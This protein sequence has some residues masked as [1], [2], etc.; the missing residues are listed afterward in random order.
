MST[1]DKAE[2]VI[3]ETGHT[4]VITMSPDKVTDKVVTDTER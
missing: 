2:Q 3:P 1:S 4:E